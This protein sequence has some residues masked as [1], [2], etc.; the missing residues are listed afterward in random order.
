MENLRRAEMGLGRPLA[1]SFGDVLVRVVAVTMMGHVEVVYVER[2]VESSQA[3][4]QAGAGQGTY[5][6]FGHDSFLPST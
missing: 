1:T 3:R 4:Q 5:S 6:P 2:G